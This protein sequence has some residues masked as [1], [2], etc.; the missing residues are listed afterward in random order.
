MSK[1]YILPKWAGHMEIRRSD[2]NPDNKGGSR[3]REFPFLHVDETLTPGAST[4]K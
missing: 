4:G 3:K 1:R 2:S